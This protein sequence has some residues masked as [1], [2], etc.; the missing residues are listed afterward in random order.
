MGDCPELLGFLSQVLGKLLKNV[1]GAG[2][3]DFL[4][5]FVGEGNDESDV[6]RNLICL[7]FKKYLQIARQAGWEPGFII[8]VFD[9]RI[10]EL[11]PLW[12]LQAN[13]RRWLDQCRFLIGI[14][15]LN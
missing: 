4:P 7:W 8:E 2:E 6:V 14:L 1:I 15:D 10:E 9:Q 13:L 5:D 12:I 11:F 3:Q